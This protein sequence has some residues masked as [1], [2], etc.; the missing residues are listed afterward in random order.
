MICNRKSLLALLFAVVSIIANNLSAQTNINGIINKYAAVTA[1]DFCNN[2]VTVNSTTGFS[3]GQ[4]VMII[5]M[6]GAEIDASNSAAFGNINDYKGCGDCEM[7]IKTITGNVIEFKYA[8]IRNYEASGSV[9]L[10]SLEEYTDA[11]VTAPLTA[12]AWDGSTGGVLL[13]KTNTLTLNDSITVK[14]KGFRGALYENDNAWQACFNNG[15]G[16]ATDYYCATIN[17][18]APK[19]EGIGTAGF[20][21]GRGKNGN[22]GGGGGDDHNT[23]GGGGSNAGAGGRGGVRS[24]TGNFCPGPAPVLAVRLL[25]TAPVQTKYLWA[26]V[27][28]RVMA[29]TIREE[30]EAMVEALLLS[31]ATP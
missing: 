18:G 3:V 27:A 29:T 30:A 11:I 4:R 17:C 7:T 5:Q 6:K 16:G 28:V 10:V 21:Y 14:G 20:N 2:N 24:N 9:Q 12:Q 31:C 22:G 13:L 8:L 25:L 23:G 1:I 15:T 26:V 19:G